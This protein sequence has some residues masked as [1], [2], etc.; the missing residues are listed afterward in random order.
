M[1]DHIDAPVKWAQP[2]QSLSTRDLVV[3]QPHREQL[4][5]GNDAVL[6]SRQSPDFTIWPLF[7]QPVLHLL[8]PGPSM[9][10]GTQLAPETR[11]AHAK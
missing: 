3:R 11:V 6:T 10:D 8:S 2:P 4:P 7:S 9:Q 5:A 1:T